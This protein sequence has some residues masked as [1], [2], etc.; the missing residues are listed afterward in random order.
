MWGYT[1]R[2]R[3]IPLGVISRMG[4]WC[5]C[6]RKIA[7][8]LDQV[9]RPLP[10][11]IVKAY[12]L[13]AQTSL[14]CW[15]VYF[16]DSMP[17]R[18][19]PETQV[20]SGK[21]LTKSKHELKRE[22]RIIRSLIS[23]AEKEISDHKQR[24][25]KETASRRCERRGAVSGMVENASDM[26]FRTDDMDINFVMRRQSVL[27]GT[28]KRRLLGNIIRNPFG[29]CVTKPF[30]FFGIQFVKGLPNTYSE[31]P[32]ITKDGREVWLGQ[33]TQL[34]VEDGKVTGFQAF[35]AISPNASNWKRR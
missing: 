11:L 7:G 26:V 1:F 21:R 13:S 28:K 34:I 24:V 3:S 22:W 35:P 16:I 23:G 30:R 32:M 5:C 6:K 20:L 25:P 31:Y 29:L 33:N 15:P 4:F 14:E 27:Q 9:L 2:L 17:R 18:I 8:H 12:F 10:V 19:F